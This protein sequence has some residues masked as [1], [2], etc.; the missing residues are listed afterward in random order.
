MKTS[1]TPR[2][3]MQNIHYGL[4]TL[5]VRAFC[6]RHFIL[7]MNEEL[8]LLFSLETLYKHPKTTTITRQSQIP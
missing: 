8:T 3:L 5:A 1:N 4:A 7:G 6:L 2:H